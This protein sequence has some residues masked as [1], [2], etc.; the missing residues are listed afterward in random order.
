MQ[1]KTKPVGHHNSWGY[2]NI[3]AA[4]EAHVEI[5]VRD[6]AIVSNKATL[7]CLIQRLSRATR[8]NP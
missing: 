4:R 2:D 1:L 6:G 8:E 5:S 7:A 3:T